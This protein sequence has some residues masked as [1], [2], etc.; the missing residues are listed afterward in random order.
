M[1]SAFSELFH[2]VCSHPCIYIFK[3][4][5]T[6][7]IVFISQYTEYVMTLNMMK[8]LSLEQIPSNSIQ[9]HI[10]K[11]VWYDTRHDFLTNLSHPTFF[12]LLVGSCVTGFRHSCFMQYL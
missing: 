11:I 10:T 6:N 8:S 4:M 1:F 3:T 12:I 2:V 5:C 9:L 7:D